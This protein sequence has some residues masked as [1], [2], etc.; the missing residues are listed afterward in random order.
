MRAINSLS[1]RLVSALGHTTEPKAKR[2]PVAPNRPGVR[3][4]C[5]TWPPPSRVLPC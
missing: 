1:S 4:A 5:D 2:Q 3:I